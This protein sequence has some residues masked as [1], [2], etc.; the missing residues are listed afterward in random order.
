MDTSK[1]CIFETLSTKELYISS[2][3]KCA[4]GFQ[5]LNKKNCKK[6]EKYSGSWDTRKKTFTYSSKMF[7]LFYTHHY[8][9]HLKNVENSC[10]QIKQYDS[11][12]F[13]S[14]NSVVLP[15]CLK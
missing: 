7:M 14:L 15:A 6:H 11:V 9:P 10:I 1:C 8:L 4:C 12:T 5:M 13:Q 2:I 3:L